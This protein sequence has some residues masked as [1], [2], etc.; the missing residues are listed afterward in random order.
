MPFMSVPSTYLTDCM[1][2]GADIMPLQAVF[3]DLRDT[4]ASSQK[5]RTSAYSKPDDSKFRNIESTSIVAV[6]NS[7]MLAMLAVRFSNIVS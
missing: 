1:K 4:S 3:V 6:R 7:E 2:F 5:P